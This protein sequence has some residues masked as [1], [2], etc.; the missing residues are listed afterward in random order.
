MPRYLLSV[1]NDYSAP[2]Q[3]PERM[4]AFYEAA[5]ALETEIRD[6]GA[7]VFG[8]GLGDPRHAVVV[9]SSGASPLMTDG[10]F[11]ETR[12]HLGGVWVV[13]VADREAALS[14]AVKAS[15]VCGA[16]IEVRAAEM[17]GNG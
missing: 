17:E 15:R 2:P 6:A 7:W 16:P 3:T 10:P 9:D 8:V 1:H 14:W 4:R 11:S 5:G 12:E 13:D